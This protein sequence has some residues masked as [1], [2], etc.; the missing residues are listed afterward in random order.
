MTADLEEAVRGAEVLVVAVP[1]HGF[2]DV[3][4][5]AAPWVHPWIPVVSLTKGFEAGTLLRMTEV[6][7]ELLPGH[8][9]AALT[10]PNLAKEI[11]AGQAAASV[12]ATEDLDG[13]RVAAGGAAA[14]ACSAST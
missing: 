2:R 5:R 8:P 10:G 3:L 14:A 4:A 1:S 7:E 13:G 9:A 6:I 11:M 12:I